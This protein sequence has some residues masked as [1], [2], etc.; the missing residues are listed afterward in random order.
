MDSRARELLKQGDRL[1]SKRMSLLSLWQE[2]A[3][4]FYV[5]RA[6]FTVAPV[7]GE[8]FAEHLMSGYP[9]M[10]RRDLGNA[11]SAMLRPNSKDWFAMRTGRPEQEDDS[12]RKFLEYATQVQ[13][14]AMYDRTAKFSRATKEGDHDFAT[15]GQCVI[16]TEINWRDISL[17]YRCWH[18]RDVAWCEDE[19]GDIGQIQRKWKPTVRDLLR[20]FPGNVH[21]NV[22]KLAE[23]DPLAE[24][25]C[26]HIMVPA[27]AYRGEKKIKHPFVSLYVDCENEH[28]MSESGSWTQHY[29]IPRWQTVSGSQYAYSPATVVALPDA[30]LLQA[31]TLTLLE[32]GEKAVD[33][34]MIAVQEALRSDIALYAGGVT[35]LDADYDEKLGEALRPLTRDLRGIPLGMEMQRA[36]EQQIREAF[37]LNKLSLPPFQGVPTAT[38]VNHAV[39]EYIRNALPLFE[40]IETEYN[41]SICEQTF[42]LL[43]RAGGFGTENDIPDSVRGTDIQFRFESPLHEAVERQKGQRLIEA[44]QLLTVFGDSDPEAM[45]LL[46]ARTALREALE[47]VG[48]PAAWLRSE[49]DMDR[50]AAVAAQQKQAQQVLALAEQAGQAAQAV[51]DGGQK[52]MGM[53]G[54]A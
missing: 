51:G 15:F 33:P 23:T 46:D 26:R 54:I 1:F 32:A 13:K 40:P 43:L 44:K 11:L 21:P 6:H 10:T 36:G 39:S 47:G 17:L 20:L 49:E 19:Y 31:I 48:T 2:I 7:L 27:E 52:I 53:G 50:I 8:E 18:L 14:R 22:S 41:A 38:Q 9:L 24:I 4:Q 5:E 12:A 28:V 3:L 35:M 34:P 45:Q 16:S 30:R 29:T 37:F 42:E 25:S